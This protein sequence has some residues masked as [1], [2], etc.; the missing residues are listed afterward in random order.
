MITAPPKK[1]EAKANS[2][3]KIQ[4]VK[5][6]TKPM[7]MEIVDFKNKKTPRDVIIDKCLPAPQTRKRTHKSTVTSSVHQAPQNDLSIEDC[8]VE[9]KDALKELAKKT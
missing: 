4:A 7:K 5:D 6:V 3:S 9:A 2:K 8:K 1:R